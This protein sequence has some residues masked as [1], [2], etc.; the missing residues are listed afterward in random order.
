MI[1][2]RGETPLIL[3]EDMEPGQIGVVRRDDNW[4]PNIGLIVKCCQSCIDPERRIY[5]GL[6]HKTI[7]FDTDGVAFQGYS[8]VEIL[9]NGTLLEITENE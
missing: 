5:A 9:P 7:F 3:M 2:I 8:Y 1:K 6:N 4:P